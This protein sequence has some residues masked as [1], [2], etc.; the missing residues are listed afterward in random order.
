MAVGKVRCTV[1]AWGPAQVHCMSCPPDL[2][3][4]LGEH[5]EI[6]LSAL[7]LAVATL[8]SVAELLKKEGLAIESSEN[9]RLCCCCCGKIMA[10]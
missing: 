1:V 6:E 4:L 5:G 2:Q 7:G 8:V 9:C 3:R 10:L